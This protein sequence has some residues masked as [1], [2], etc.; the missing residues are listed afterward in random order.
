MIGGCLNHADDD[1]DEDVIKAPNMDFS[2]KNGGFYVIFM[3]F[4]P[5][6]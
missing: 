3:H 4:L 5:Y 6:L 1:D 2:I